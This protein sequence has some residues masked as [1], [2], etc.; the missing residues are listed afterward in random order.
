MQQLKH[1]N[2]ILEAVKYLLKIKSNKN[3]NNHKSEPP[4]ADGLTDMES[5]HKHLYVRYYIVRFNIYS[6]P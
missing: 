3:D 2:Y 1:F 4:K 5:R 6:R